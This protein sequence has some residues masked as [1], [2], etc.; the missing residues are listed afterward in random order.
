MPRIGQTKFPAHL[1]EF[2]E[3]AVPCFFV[4]E[5]QPA[6]GTRGQQFIR[7]GRFEARLHQSASRSCCG[8]REQR[9]YV[10]SFDLSSDADPGTITFTMVLLLI[11]KNSG[12]P[13]GSLPR[14]KN[15]LLQLWLAWPNPGSPADTSVATVAAVKKTPHQAGAGATAMRRT[16]PRNGPPWSTP[17]GGGPLKREFRPQSRQ[18]EGVDHQRQYVVCPC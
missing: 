3:L 7:A 5:A 11:N 17:V 4:A 10:G 1:L 2:L 12:F 13:G 18:T 15:Q 14:R 6:V 9:F 16:N 8:F